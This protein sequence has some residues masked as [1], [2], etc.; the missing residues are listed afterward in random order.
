MPLGSL[1]SNSKEI[2]LPRFQVDKIDFRLVL[3]MIVNAINLP[4]DLLG[5]MIN[6]RLFKN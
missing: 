6:P 1:I 3:V 2:P 5:D 4:G